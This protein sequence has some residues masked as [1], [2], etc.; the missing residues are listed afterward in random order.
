MFVEKLILIVDDIDDEVAYIQELVA[1]CGSR[2]ERARDWREAL[3]LLRSR[4]VDG[5]FLDL[6]LGTTQEDGFILMERMLT[7]KLS[8]PTQIVSHTADLV[9]VIA[10][11]SQYPF[12]RRAPIPKKDIHVH[13]RFIEEFIRDPGAPVRSVR[14]DATV[15]I[16][17]GRDHAQR[18]RIASI[19]QGLGV[20]PVIL[21]RA[22]RE[23]ATLIELF[24]M[25]ASRVVYAIV[26]MTGDDV[27][28]LGTYAAGKR[29]RA[30][31]NVVFELG[32]FYG[33]IGRNRV[34]CLTQ[35]DVE[36]PSDID[37]IVYEDLSR[38]DHEIERRIMKELQAVG[39]QFA[40]Q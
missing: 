21:D 2:F 20:T 37:G 14:G 23:G 22:A 39:V 7:E 34:L 33:K 17:H 15:F 31:Q 25:C 28:Y 10:A 26:V 5:L 19:L 29:L 8:V 13:R 36:R 40:L 38:S 24:E 9:G 30:R 1:G 18:D 4:H 27:G 32:F 16:V 3:E 11:C 35:P 12:V 6:N